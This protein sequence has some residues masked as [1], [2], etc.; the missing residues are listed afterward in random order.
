MVENINPSEEHQKNKEFWF[1]LIT[2]CLAGFSWMILIGMKNSTEIS[3]KI[4]LIISIV[5]TII[6]FVSIFGKRIYSKFEKQEKV[7]IEIPPHLSEDKVEKIIDEKIKNDF[8]TWRI[9]G[10]RI[11]QITRNI[12]NNI[13]YGFFETLYSKR[14]IGGINTNRCAILVNATFPEIQPQVLPIEEDGR[15]KNL[16]KNINLMSRNPKDDPRV[17]KTVVENEITGTRSTTTETTPND[18]KSKEQ[19]EKRVV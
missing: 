14:K 16:E 18:N 15:I 10:G 8:W 2:A 11:G 6:F 7:S 13:I 19:E 17:R 1:K 5:L 12:N 3:L 9:P 4:P